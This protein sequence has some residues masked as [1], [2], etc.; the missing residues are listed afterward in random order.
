MANSRV[1]QGIMKPALAG[2][3]RILFL[4]EYAP[5]EFAPREKSFA[6]DGGYPEYHY[7]IWKT[8][9]DIGYLMRSSSQPTSAL[10]ARG[11]IDFVFSLYNRMPLNNSEVLVSAF[12]EYARVPYLGA[13][14]NIRAL[15]EDKWLSKLAAR[16]IG[17][18]TVAGMPYG[19]EGALA[20][21]PKFRGPYFV[22]DR[23][24]AGSEGIS[25]NSLQDTWAGAKELA[26]R[27]IGQG[28][29]VLVE[30]YAPGIDVTVPVLGGPEPIMLGVVH[31]RSNEPGKILT[32]NLK[33]GD[34]L[35]YELFE[36]GEKTLD[37]HADVMALWSA[38]GP[39]DYLRMDYRY[40]ATTGQRVFLEFNICCYIGAD[41]AICLAGADHGLTQSD[42]LGH[43]VEFSL[44]RQGGDR[45]H[46][47]W[48]L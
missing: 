45:K 22:K 29:P 34:P 16:A 2:S 38:T 1:A 15:A 41:G 23:F 32:E 17:I 28:I 40:D 4:A 5:D 18:P 31:P 6:G 19:C 43:V 33:L 7:W 35:G 30:Q 26:A 42:I 8:L 12:C 3:P 39:I 10:F 48:I 37:I 24:G 11:N 27:R 46:L 20:E 47:Q 9:G 13:S 36:M 25:T 14:P 21:P 44:R